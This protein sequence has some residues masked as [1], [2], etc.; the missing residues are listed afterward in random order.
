MKTEPD[1]GQ[2]P[3]PEVDAAP[4]LAAL[5][6]ATGEFKYETDPGWQADDP[7]AWFRAVSPGATGA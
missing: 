3:A 1:P 4:E 6:E 5:R 7:I 2:D